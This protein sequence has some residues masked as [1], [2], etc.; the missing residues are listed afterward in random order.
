M[1]LLVGEIEFLNCCATITASILNN[2]LWEFYLMLGESAY[3]G[4]FKAMKT[5][6]H[7]RYTCV[8]SVT[9]LY[10]FGTYNIYYKANRGAGSIY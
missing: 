6:H 3:G 7:T 9:S 1:F 8:Q 4:I 10:Q 5:V 2:Y